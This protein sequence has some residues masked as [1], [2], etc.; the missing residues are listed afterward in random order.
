MRCF[1]RD[2]PPILLQRYPAGDRA[3]QRER[4]ARP[5]WPNIY[6]AVEAQADLEAL[7]LA[8]RLT[9]R[10][11]LLTRKVQAMVALAETLPENQP[12]YVNQRSSFLAGVAT[13]AWAAADTA[14]Q[15]IKG[16][17][18]LRGGSAWLRSI[19]VGSGAAAT[20]A[21]LELVAAGL[22]PVMLDVGYMDDGAASRV[23]GN[24][25]RYR[26]Q[27][28]SFDLHIGADYRGL[29]GV[30]SGRAGIAKLNA[31]RMAFVTRDAA[32]LGPLSQA[33][34]QAIQSFA[35][36]GLGNAWGAGLYRWIDADL[37]DFPISLAELEP[38][39]DVLT[40][41][42]GIS[43]ADDD[44]A[45]FFGDPTGL[46]PPLELSHNARRV[47]LAYRRRRKAPAGQ[48]HHPGPAARGRAVRAQGRPPGLRLQQPGVLAVPALRLHAGRH[49][50][51]LIA[52]GQID[53]RPGLLV[54]RWKETAD[55]VTVHA[56]D[57]R[58]RRDRS[59]STGQR[60]L[61]AAGAI[62]TARIA[63]QS[64]ATPSTPAPAGKPDPADPAGAARLAGPPAGHPRLWPGAAQP[65]LG[66]ACLPDA[67]AGQPDR[68]N[69]AAALRVLQ[70][71]S[72]VGAGQPGADP[73]PAAGYADA[74]ALLPGLGAAAV[75]PVAAGRWPPAHRG[76]ALPGRA[77]S[78]WRRC[79]PRCAAWACGRTR[80]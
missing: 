79:W 48:A 69:R 33:K 29:A 6:R 12:F 7:E 51:R 66:V 63:L 52:A 67:P 36:G 57:V 74:A 46:Q 44:L 25:Y 15:G 42:I 61:L 5:S 50:A 32:T 55:G 62:N 10:L 70:P 26:R 18:L 3:A 28:D 8:G 27:H 38:Y 45:E 65:G 54:Q 37:Q 76:P 56:S 22:R 47:A 30:L 80:R 43:G 68:A 41:E 11:P 64:A 75:A 72:F 77:G 19:I 78:S 31:P 23:E 20:A 34:F 53:Y 71:L 24:L 73:P 60:L 13:L 1:D 4:P 21:A 49:A 16:L 35:L 58:Q 39:F 2:I 40:R 14:R 17:W 59:R 9:G